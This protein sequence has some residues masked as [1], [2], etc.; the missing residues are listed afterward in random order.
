M[1]L[2][3]YV[4]VFLDRLLRLFLF[5]VVALSLLM[6]ALEVKLFNTQ[7]DK[8]NHN[9]SEFNKNV[10]TIVYG[11]AKVEKS[12]IQLRSSFEERHKMIQPELQSFNTS[13]DKL[14]YYLPYLINESYS[15]R[16]E[17]PDILHEIEKI[18][19]QAEDV[20]KAA[21]EGAVEGAM[22]GVLSLP[23]ELI[24]SIITLPVEAVKKTGEKVFG[25]D[26][27][28]V[29]KSDKLSEVLA[30]SKVEQVEITDS[31]DNAPAKG[32]EKSAEKISS[33]NINSSEESVESKAE[34]KVEQSI[35]SKVKN[36]DPV[37]ELLKKHMDI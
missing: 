30:V 12:V 33:S 29:P 34:G 27:P 7:F 31:K 6:V 11:V 25:D 8:F 22:R 2:A 28:K 26:K 17:L 19:G 4:F 3:N 9:I 32:C 10:P 21:S 15:L 1:L 16:K 5:S 35:P 23:A 24:S 13:F 36:S 14:N 37:E 18:V 20:S